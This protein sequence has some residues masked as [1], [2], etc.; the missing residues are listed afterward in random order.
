MNII[1]TWIINGVECYPNHAGENNVVFKV[2]W[3][4]TGSDE[5]TGIGY[6]GYVSGPVELTYEAG[7]TFTPYADLTENQ[8]INWVKDS[9]GE[10]KIAELKTNITEQIKIQLTPAVVT[11]LLPWSQGA[12]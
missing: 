6:G 5:S 8:V 2:N 11:P 7:T 9:L 10:E 4:L 1:Y 3:G 12:A